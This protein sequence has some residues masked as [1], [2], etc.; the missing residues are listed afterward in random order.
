MTHHI[1]KG[2]S[3]YLLS[4]PPASGKSTFLKNLSLPTGA[5]LSSDTIREQLFGTQ[6][7]LV[8]S[9]EGGWSEHGHLYGWDKPGNVVFDLMMTMCRERLREGLVTFI[10]ATLLTDKEREPF[11]KIA[12]ALCVPVEVL[13]FEV[14]LP[15]LRRR[16]QARYA[17]VSDSVLTAMHA[18]HQHKSAYPLRTVL[19]EDTVALEPRTLQGDAYDVVGDVHGLLD[20]FLVLVKKLGYQH[21]EEGIPY[22]PDGRKLVFLGDV[23]D[24]GTQ[25]VLLLHYIEQAVRQG[26]HTFVVGNH[27]DKLLKTWDAWRR[28]GEA[29]G[30]SRSSTETFLSL[31][32]HP[33]AEQERLMHFIRTQPHFALIEGHTGEQFACVHSDVRV[34]DPLWTPRSAVLYG[35][36]DFGRL[37]SDAHYEM[38]Y[39]KGWNRY[40]LL[41]GHIEQ[42][43]P[44][45]HV[46]SVEFDQAFAG[47]LAALRL[48]RFA[49]A[50]AS[51]P[52]ADGV[53][54]RELFESCA[55][56]VKVDFH[57]DAHVRSKY[58]V[59][60]ALVKYAKDGV[61]KSYQDKGTGMQTFDWGDARKLL[62]E[63]L[64]Q[65]VSESGKRGVEAS[66]K[67]SESADDLVLM[68]YSKAVFWNNLWNKHPF[69]LKARGLVVD[70]AGG[71]VQHPFDKIFNYGENGTALDISDDTT[72]E[73]VEK[74][75]GFLG[76]ITKHPYKND[77]LVTTTG[78]FDS[79]FVQYIQ[80]FVT[81]EL[82]AKLMDHFAHT[83]ETLM[84][85]VIHPEDNEHPVQYAPE[86]QGLWLIGARAK[87]W[88]AP[89]KNE[90]YLDFL[91]SDFG[92]RR[93]TR[94]IMS[95]GE[96]RKLAQTEQGEGF[97]VLHDGT[98]VVKFKTTHYLALKFVGRLG[99]E[100]MRF[101]Y[102]DA[103]K[104]KQTLD[105]EYVDLVDAVIQ[106][107]PTL[108]E[109][110]ALS[111]AERM[112]FVRQAVT[113]MRVEGEHAAQHDEQAS[114]VLSMVSGP[115]T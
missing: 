31:M 24:R 96:V 20:E 83:D 10:D 5:V 55:V 109:W 69:L 16:N 107:Y 108:E 75:N 104:F 45:R 12:H 38:G 93:P 64:I 14:P 88:N 61:L 79:P 115:S 59:G 15:E 51:E 49:A 100:K 90:D 17:R 42:I 43:S 7:R 19:A 73:V 72:V 78:S 48:D 8:S 77:L 44:Q 33:M 25:S 114:P 76:C 110:A 94:R 85:E 67:A 99:N 58:A 3:L 40:T 52:G 113:T 46:H 28:T 41:R 1:L 66:A 47:H 105:E 70:Q 26:G 29:R 50:L 6:P 23:V 4:G 106:T 11:A 30:R 87:Q 97:I 56:K 21:N 91:G 9:D 57:Y 54:A 95:F 35:D 34:F 27:E 2:G 60:D 80:S 62:D 82:K 81:P 86:E 53:R 37:D 103:A 68:K 65:L 84:F 111:A 32:A 13:S 74:L 71:I 102:R 112:D 18:G 36:S 39:A 22:H 101:M 63:R 92:L 98:P 89:L